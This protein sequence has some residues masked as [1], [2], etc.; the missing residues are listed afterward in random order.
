[1]SQHTGYAA[2]LDGKT[3]Y[4]ITLNEVEE[5]TRHDGYTALIL[6]GTYKDHITYNGECVNPSPSYP[7]RIN[8]Y[9]DKDKG[10]EKGIMDGACAIT[11]PEG[12]EEYDLHYTCAKYLE[13]FGV[14][15]MHAAVYDM[16]SFFYNS[17]HSCGA[18]W[19]QKVAN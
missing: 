12:V 4:G 7:V 9:Y 3:I 19:F 15:T 2:I 17:L 10:V 1:M 11:T 5:Y 6:S 8:L 18:L 13:V 14:C 16:A